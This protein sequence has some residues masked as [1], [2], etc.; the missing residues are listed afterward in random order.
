MDL[1]AIRMSNRQFM[2]VVSQLFP[3]CTIIHVIVYY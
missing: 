3:N 2:P 1:S